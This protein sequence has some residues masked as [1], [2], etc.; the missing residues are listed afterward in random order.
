MSDKKQAVHDYWN[1]ASC[2]EALY[3]IDIDN[4]G[5]EAQAKKRY[6]LE[7]NRPAGTPRGFIL[8][9]YSMGA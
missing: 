9:G 5:Y 7:R 3:L 4:V 1:V 2:G 6:E 8:S